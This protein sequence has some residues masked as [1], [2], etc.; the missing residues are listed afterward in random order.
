MHRKIVLFLF[1][2]TWKFKYCCLFNKFLCL[3]FSQDLF[4][5]TMNSRNY[6]G[7]KGGILEKKIQGTPK[8]QLM[9]NKSYN[10]KDHRKMYISKRGRL[11]MIDGGLW[12]YWKETLHISQLGHGDDCWT[13]EMTT[14]ICK[15]DEF[16]M[17]LLFL[18]QKKYTKHQR[19]LKINYE[20]ESW[21][22]KSPFLAQKEIALINSFKRGIIF[23]F[24]FFRQIDIWIIVNIFFRQGL[25]DFSILGRT[26]VFDK[27]NFCMYPVEYLFCN[28]LVFEIV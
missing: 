26:L 14:L 11:F 24:S 20:I 27:Y 6:K 16:H 10:T 23:F 28:Y 18:I 9:K 19:N 21:L 7:T 5:I 17:K 22:K 15:N 1:F 12:S 3:Y 2:N 4:Y 25:L 8:I 13:Y